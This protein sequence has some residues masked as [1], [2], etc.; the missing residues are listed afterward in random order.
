MSKK[1]LIKK[2]KKV[3]IDA[4]ERVVSEF[5]KHYVDADKDYHT[6]YGII[7]KKD[8]L[9]KPGSSVPVGNHEFIILDPAFLDHYKRIRRMAQIIT[10]K[11]I[12]AII[13][14]T[15]ITKDSNVLDAGSGSGASESL[16][17]AAGHHSARIS[18]TTS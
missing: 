7:N 6:K 16:P 8:L 5:E 15:G 3:E 11:D 17:R 9:K 12:G 4:K 2:Q 14:S 13:A 10:L 1:I 18:L